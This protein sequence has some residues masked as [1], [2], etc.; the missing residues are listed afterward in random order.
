MPNLQYAKCSCKA[1]VLFPLEKNYKSIIVEKTNEELIS[2]NEFEDVAVIILDKDK[3]LAINPSVSKIQV[4]KE[5]K[6]FDAFNIKGFPKA[7]KGKELATIFA[8][9]LHEMIETNRFQL[10]LNSDYTATNI[11]GFS[12][13][14]IFLEANNE[15]YLY[16][17]FTRFREDERGKVIYC[18]YVDSVN[19]LLK[20][21]FIP[22]INYSYL[23]EKGLTPLFFVNQ[24]EREIKNLGPRFNEELNFELPISRVFDSISKSAIYRQNIITKTDKWLT[25]KGYRKLKDNELLKEI[26]IELENLRQEIKDWLI[27]F[28]SHSFEEEITIL[29]LIENVENLIKSDVSLSCKLLKIINSAYYSLTTRVKSIRNAIMII[30]ID[31]LKR[32]IFVMELKAMNKSSIEELTKISLIRGYFGEFIVREID[33]GVEIFDVFLTGLFSLIDALTNQPLD[34]ILIELPVSKNVKDALAGKQNMLSKLL[35]LIIKYEKGIW[36]EVN[37]I[38]E[39]IGLDNAFVI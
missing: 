8:T 22:S 32:W 36:E 13:G 38:V 15:I 18:Q 4:I 20:K 24:V 19:K 14:G 6:S 9:W 28:Q 3:V 1:F 34:K 10:Q 11:E 31:E 30:G 23:G 17:I 29:P 37:I 7:T 21:N 25:E 33:F 26:E 16:G 35:D 5:R 39:K 12:G 27:K 2:K